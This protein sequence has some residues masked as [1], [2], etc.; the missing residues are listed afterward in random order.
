MAGAQA[1][2]PSLPQWV[3]LELLPLS[4]YWGKISP[5]HRTGSLQRG[6]N[7]VRQSVSLQKTPSQAR[8][9]TSVLL[10]S[11]QRI[12]TA[13]RQALTLAE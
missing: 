1:L 13:L 12:S 3:V 8:Q 9:A 2:P 5:K 6:D 10:S 11:K 7:L 4:Q